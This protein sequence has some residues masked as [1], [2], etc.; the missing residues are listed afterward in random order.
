MRIL[1]LLAAGG[2]GG[3]EILIKNIMENSEE[4]NRVCFMFKEGTI[5]NQL[6]EKYGGSKII[7]LKDKKIFQKVKIIEEYCL[8]EK[9]QIIILHHEG[10]KNNLVYIKLK[11]KMKKNNIK[12]VRY[13]HSSYDDYY[14]PYKN[15]MIK[16]LYDKLIK[17]TINI[18]DLVI[19]ISNKVRQTFNE[20]LNIKG[21]REV[22]IYNGVDDKFFAN[23]PN[24]RVD[25][26][27]NIIY[28]GR[29]SKEKGVDFLINAFAIVLKECK[30]LRVKLKIIGDGNEKNT[31]EKI[32]NDNKI[33]K[34]IEFLGRKNNVIEHLDKSDI[35]VYPSV[36]EEG[37]GISVVEAMARG[38]IVVTFEKGGLPEIIDDGE[39]GFLVKNVDENS[40]ANK[41][42]DI[43]NLMKNEKCANIIKKSEED[44]KKYTI[45]STVKNLSIELNNI[46]Q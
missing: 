38:C 18:S 34:S 13:M 10:I 42:L 20:R 26:E 12:L 11:N 21:N 33:E 24:R 45:K 9:V 35:F 37:F 23:V 39:N 29:L 8:R 30:E 1:H 40:L 2:I 41:L 28:V 4:D 36:C 16:K 6:F 14:N 19:Y 31:L 5:Y 3:I 17:Q 27:I 43:I 46:L 7:S 15:G 32:A 22:V 25:D 44:A